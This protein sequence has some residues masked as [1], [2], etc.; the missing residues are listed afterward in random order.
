[1]SVLF[2]PP[3]RRSRTARAWML[4]LSEPYGTAALLRGDS[5]VRYALLNA[6][7]L[8]YAEFREPVRL[9]YVEHLCAGHLLYSEMKPIP[10]HRDAARALVV[11]PQWELGEYR[12]GGQ[13]A[14]CD[15]IPFYRL[16]LQETP[17]DDE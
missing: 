7:G 2:P 3:A 12:A 1:M 16:N 8:C 13:G 15:R 6:A 11:D 14:R 17:S 5:S 10:F 4:Q 9:H